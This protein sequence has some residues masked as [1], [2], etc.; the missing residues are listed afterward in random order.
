MRGKKPLTF[1]HYT[2]YCIKLYVFILGKKNLFNYT[3][4][5][6]TEDSS[7]DITVFLK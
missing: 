4:S 3:E 5:F 1:K 6:F 2:A 7:Q